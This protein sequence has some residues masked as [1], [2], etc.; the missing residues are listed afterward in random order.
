M[1]ILIILIVLVFYFLLSIKTRKSIHMLQQ[2]LYNENNRYLKWVIKN[3]DDFISFEICGILLIFFCRKYF[4]DY[5]GV[6]IAISLAIILCCIYV[7][8]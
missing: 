1:K 8:C 2:N 4:L 6:V 5:F 7:F 3:K